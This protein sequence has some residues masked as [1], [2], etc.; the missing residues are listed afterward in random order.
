MLHRVGLLLHHGLVT[1][2]SGHAQLEEECLRMALTGVLLSSKSV[3]LLVGA[4]EAFQALTAGLG[5]RHGRELCG[6]VTQAAR[7]HWE[8][9][10][11]RDKLLDRYTASGDDHDREDQASEAEESSIVV[12]DDETD[13]A[14]D[15]VDEDAQKLRQRQS[16]K[17]EL[18]RQCGLLIELGVDALI[19]P[20]LR[21]AAHRM[22]W[23]GVILSP[24][25][26]AELTKPQVIATLHRDLHPRYLARL[27]ELAVA[28]HADIELAYI[29]T[30]ILEALKS[31]H[32]NVVVVD[33]TPDA[34]SLMSTPMQVTP[35]DDADMTDVLI[36][37]TDDV[38]FSVDDCLREAG[39]V[40][41]A[42][43]A[44]MAGHPS[45]LEGLQ[46]MSDTGEP[47]SAAFLH[48]LADDALLH[49]LV[50]RLSATDV[51]NLF[52]ELA[53]IVTA[54]HPDGFSEFLLAL[55]IVLEEQ[56]LNGRDDLGWLPAAAAMQNMV[57]Q[58]TK[59]KKGRFLQSLVRAI[60]FKNDHG[61]PA[62]SVDT[63]MD[64]HSHHPGHKANVQVAGKLLHELLECGAS[65][66]NLGPETVRAVHR[67]ASEGVMLNKE[68]VEE[69][70]T[71][72]VMRGAIN[73]DQIK[74]HHVRDL[75]IASA[76][77]A[78]TAITSQALH[79]AALLRHEFQTKHGPTNP[80][81]E[82]GDDKAEQAVSDNS[83]APSHSGFD[84][85]DPIHT[86]SIV[87]EGFGNVE[88]WV[89]ASR[90]EID[91]EVEE[92][93]SM[94]AHKG[95][96][97]AIFGSRR[98]GIFRDF[99]QGV[100][101]LFANMY[102]FKTF[103][104]P[105]L[106]F[107]SWVFLRLYTFM[108]FDFGDTFD[109]SSMVMVGMALFVLAMLVYLHWFLDGSNS[110]VYVP[111]SVQRLLQFLRCR[112]CSLPKSAAAPP[113]K[114]PRNENPSA[115]ANH[116]SVVATKEDAIRLGHEAVTWEKI[117]TTTKRGVSQIQHFTWSLTFFLTIYF[118]VTKFG[119]QTVFQSN[120]L[121]T[122]AFGSHGLK[123]DIIWGFCVF[124]LVFFSLT[125]F[126]ILWVNISRNQPQGSDKKPG[127][128]YDMDGELVEFTDDVYDRLVNNHPNQIYCPYRTLYRGFE[129]KWSHY[130]LY[131]FLFK[132]ALLIPILFRSSFKVR[133]ISSLSCSAVVL[134]ATLYTE[135]Y[136]DSIDDMME[137]TSQ[138]TLTITSACA[139]ALQLIDPTDLTAQ[140]IIGLVVNLANCFNFVVVVVCLM[141][142]LESTRVGIKNLFGVFTFSD[143][144]HNISDGISKKVVVAWEIDRE[145]KH[146]VWHAFW[147]NALYNSKAKAELFQRLTRLEIAAIETGVDSIKQHWKDESDE[148]VSY[149]RIATRKHLEGVDVFWNDVSGARDG[150]LDSAT[151]FGKMYVVPYPY[152]CVMVYDDCDDQVI[153]D[154]K[155]QFEKFCLLNFSPKIRAKRLIRQQLRAL[156]AWGGEIEAPMVR[157]ERLT[158][159]VDDPKHADTGHQK[160]AHA[161][162]QCHYTMA[163]V[164][165]SARSTAVM[166]AGFSVDV[167]HTDGCGEVSISETGEVHRPRNRRFQGGLECLGLNKHMEII[168]PQWERITTKYRAELRHH[169]RMVVHEHQKYR[170]DLI[171]QQVHANN[172]MGDGFWYYVFNNPT[173][174]RVQ[175]ENYLR[176]HEPNPALQH[177]AQQNRS[178]L[179]F[180]YKRMDFV[181]AHPAFMFWFVFWEDVWSRNHT[182]SIMKP[183]DA[184]FN[185]SVH[186]SICYRVLPRPELEKVLKE[187][188][189][190]GTAWA[191]HRFWTTG[192]MFNS[193][194]IGLL[195]AKMEELCRTGLRRP[196]LRRNSSALLA[197][198]TP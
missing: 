134:A 121:V 162:F 104:G 78:S 59:E 194:N 46:H 92:L 167:T 45:M 175:L 63:V 163:K 169:V 96:I 125:F 93:Q 119:L 195:Y 35:M 64:K 192:T 36:S 128:A 87:E 185:P 168:G 12:D 142:N 6:V 126:A 88:Q 68:H 13:D 38:P 74:P 25:Y 99:A 56:F 158:V 27:K 103:R 107:T 112:G 44:D 42:A 161:E 113:H 43:M 184:L 187:H 190:W 143:T 114:S 177:F 91:H 19:S 196:S 98:F 141:L 133:T 157:E 53:R 101:V 182:M 76:R 166:A 73:Q 155:E 40:L 70:A 198:T 105:M 137:T 90:D 21:E 150:H 55:H 8:L 30:Q 50:A 135:P 171:A 89:L 100:S 127:Y 7:H 84:I 151:F 111:T 33:M 160:T 154:T 85:Y 52:S 77:I 28:A 82:N 39:R 69:L 71:T 1:G 34:P 83:G 123:F 179:D 18:I 67:M 4:A 170:D 115:S 118:P 23:E 65:P 145:C 183:L 146:R 3:A 152:S 109:T 149:L 136:V 95:T 48:E 139:L 14:V 144:V 197:Q 9:V 2:H 20:G 165:V 186:T 49:H 37:M 174:P 10:P 122:Q 102:D 140:F 57:T 191:W 81:F 189:L 75:M 94:T 22:A 173:L 124:F 24:D 108:N 181:N 62:L 15:S 72:G 11:L 86:A 5:T 47:V 61:L 147:T 110:M 193:Q 120:S 117:A 29:G 41:H 164:R 178:A 32:D 131:Q 60:S 188:R 130:R 17:N 66:S 97:M 138:I 156:S 58:P 106:R 180:L 129:R 79:L 16:D 176:D 26:L 54:T 153:I 148:L 116:A 159:V 51:H 132:V 172:I 80:S 31:C